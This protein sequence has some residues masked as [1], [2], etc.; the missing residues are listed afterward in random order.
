MDFTIIQEIWQH[1]RESL[2][3]SRMLRKEGIENIESEEPLQSLL[4]P[5]FSVR[6]GREKVWTTDKS[7]VY[8]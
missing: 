3:M 5:C 2:M 6:A 8:D 7:F 1:H 4:L